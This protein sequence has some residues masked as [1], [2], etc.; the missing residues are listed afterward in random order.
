MRIN[1]DQSDEG[2][3]RATLAPNCII[4]GK[5]GMLLYPD[6]Q[7]LLF[8]VPGSWNYK[9]CSDPACGSVWL[10]PKPLQEDLWKAYKGYYTHTH[11]REKSHATL[12]RR[13]FQLMKQGYLAKNFGYAIDQNSLW[14]TVLGKLLYLLPILRREVEADIRFLKAVPNGRLLDVGCGDGE[15]LVSMHTLGWQVEGIDFD[16]QAVEAARQRGV[17]AKCGILQ[18]QAFP[19]KSFDAVTLNHVIE[20]VSEPVQTVAECA[21][22]LKPGGKLILLT[23]NSTSLSHR[24]FKDNWRGL[25]PPRH[26]HLFSMG[27]IQQLLIM[28]GFQNILIQPFIVTSVIY[29]SLLLSRNRLDPARRSHRNGPVRLMTRLFK[30]MELCLLNYDPAAGDCVIAVAVKK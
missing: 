22:I 10:D 20:H 6:Q 3:I 16:C 26:L 12:L 4:C 24:L 8:N 1:D 25:E 23:P 14:A 15:W 13:T 17:R 9:K 28:G 7:D 2:K 29:E 19:D 11:R 27:S 5:A 30:L 18:Q 21:R